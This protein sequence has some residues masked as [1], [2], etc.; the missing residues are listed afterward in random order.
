MGTVCFEAEESALQAIEKMNE[1]EM[2]GRTIYVTKD[3][4]AK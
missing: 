1:Y 4:F 3:K 2:E